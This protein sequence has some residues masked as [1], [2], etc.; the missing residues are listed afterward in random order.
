MANL[1]KF[2]IF[3]FST[4]DSDVYKYTS[5]EFLKLTCKLGDNGIV[6]SYG[7]K[8]ACTSSGLTI[9]MGTG[10]ALIG[11]RFGYNESSKTFSLDA[12]SVGTSRI[13][14]IVIAADIANRVFKQA[15]V[16]GIAASTPTTPALTQ[17]ATYFE[18]PIYKATVSNTSTVTLVDE[19]SLIYTN[20]ELLNLINSHTQAISTITGLQAALDGKAAVSHSQAIST[21]TNLQT[22]LDQRIK[23]PSQEQY[24]NADAITTTGFA[25]KSTSPFTVLLHLEGVNEAVQLTS[26]GRIRK[27]SGSTWGSYI[28]LFDV[29]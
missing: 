18:I 28:N 15:V 23:I 14:R 24:D 9:T 3:D 13:D 12:V 1:D 17:T 16:K 2:G 10:M 6:N 8:F 7:N 5:E 21:I 22:V 19:R 11:G 4:G 29:G 26:D 25:K 20:V 27:R